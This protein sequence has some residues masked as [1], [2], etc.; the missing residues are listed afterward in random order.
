MTSWQPIATAPKNPVHEGWSVGPMVY[1]K[2][3]WGGWTVGQWVIYKPDPGG[4]TDVPVGCWRFVGDDGPHDEEPTHWM[5]IPSPEEIEVEY[6][7]QEEDEPGA[8]V[9]WNYHATAEEAIDHMNSLPPT[10]GSLRVVRTFIE[11]VAGIVR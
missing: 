5:P 4:Q 7:V 11:T 2:P 1:L 8:W 9:N 6:F 10:E 3:S